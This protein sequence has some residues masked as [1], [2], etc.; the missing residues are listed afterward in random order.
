[1][2]QQPYLFPCPAC[3]G[4]VASTATSCP[5]CGYRPPGSQERTAIDA[6]A[7]A[8]AIG[9]GLIVVG[10]FMP[11]ASVGPFSMNGTDGDGIFTLGIGLILAVLA[12]L[13]LGGRGMGMT[14]RVLAVLGGAAAVGI[15]LLDGSD[16]MDAP[17]SLIEVSV[18]AGMYVVGIGGAVVALAGLAAR[19]RA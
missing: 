11:W 12:V 8:L 9:A 17:L 16:L 3:N 10:S 14:V 19:R 7:V 5:H 13:N 2:A 6:S 15:V 4:Q 18:G 1:M